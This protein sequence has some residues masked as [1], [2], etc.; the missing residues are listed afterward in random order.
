MDATALALRSAFSTRRAGGPAEP[1]GRP[2]TRLGLAGL[3][4]HVFFELA[5]GV[6]MPFA[7]IAGP[8]PA[9]GMWT[10]GTG[11]LWRAAKTRPASADPVFAAVNGLGLA[12]IVAHMAG[13]PR[14]RTR[15]GLPWLQDC[16]GLGPE[17][18]RFYNPI[19]YA[20]GA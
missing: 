13:W 8:V 16:E 2:A 20:G 11:G 10:V 5:A 6:G 18:M 1:R 4:A 17:L 3:A 19:L 7:S 12:A 14:R 15:L 9:A